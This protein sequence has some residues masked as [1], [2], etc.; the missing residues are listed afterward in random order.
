MLMP[1]SA[2]AAPCSICR[3][4]HARAEENVRPAPLGPSRATVNKL[5]ALFSVD[6]FAGGFVAQSMLVLWLYE[7]FDLSLSAAGWFFFGSSRIG[8]T[9]TLRYPSRAL[10]WRKGAFQD[11]IGILISRIDMSLAGSR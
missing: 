11:D 3:V 2:F 4:P 6:A 10:Q 1:R 7:R 5:A 9:P 8:K